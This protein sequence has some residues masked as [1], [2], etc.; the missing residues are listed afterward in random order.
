MGQ[1]T[2]AV[3]TPYVIAGCALPP[4]PIAEDGP[5]ETPEEGVP[6]ETEPERLWRAYASG[7]FAEFAITEAAA[8]ATAVLYHLTADPAML[9]FVAGVIAFMLLRLPAILI[10]IVLNAVIGFVT[11]WKAEAALGALRKQAVPVAQALRKRA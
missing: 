4:P 2:V 5:P 8:V 11:E 6:P 10:V 1:P 7:K 9:A 3:T